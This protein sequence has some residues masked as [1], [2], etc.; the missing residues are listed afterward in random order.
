MPKNHLI[1][2]LRVLEEEHKDLDGILM[3]VQE[4]KTVNFLQIQR[5][6]KRKLILKDKINDLKN[7][8]EPDIIA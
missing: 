4:K 5:L 1:E 6:K 7:R 3:Q 2:Q 8:I